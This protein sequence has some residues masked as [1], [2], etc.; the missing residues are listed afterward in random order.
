MLLGCIADDLTGATDLSLMLS[1]EGM[2]T[3]QTTGIPPGDMD[4][5]GIDALV[6]ALKSRSI[7]AKEAVSISLDAARCLR[8]LGARRYLFKYCSTFDSTDEGNIGPVLEAL[9][10]FVGGGQTIAC[11]AFPAAGRTIYA[12]HLFVNGVLL[13]ESPMKD[14]PLNPMHDSDLRR[15][16]QRQTRLSVGLVGFEDVDGGIEA[17]DGAL[18]REAAAGRPVSIVDALS[19]RHLRD[20]GA[21]TADHVLITGGSGIAIGLPAAYAAKGL[22]AKLTPP[23]SAMPAPAGRR[24]IIAGSCSQATRRQ[25]DVAHQRGMAALHV[26]VDQLLDGSQTVESILEWT[27]RQ[28]AG[29]PFLVYSSADP[30][31]VRAAQEKLGREAAGALVE[32]TLSAVA[33]GCMEAGVTQF[34][35]AGGETSGAVVKALDAKLLSIGPEIDPGVPWTR[36]LGHPDLALALKSG[37]FGAPDFFYKAWDFLR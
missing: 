22:L 23:G 26:D 34:L 9:L 14:H 4:L 35:V 18:K 28:D 27:S 16:L 10:D 17:I 19:D 25:I 30:A 12:G 13:S 36:T 21:A 24:A 33:K 3:V 37:N 7:P 32:G 8:D 11:P 6:I 29:Q 31:E 15:V 1:R 5:D 2:R 20:I